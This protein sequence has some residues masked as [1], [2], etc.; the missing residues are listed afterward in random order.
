M[1][2]DLGHV[3]HMKDL[4]DILAFGLPHNVKRMCRSH[5]FF[6]ALFALSYVYLRKWHKERCVVDICMKV[7]I[8]NRISLVLCLCKYTLGTF[9]V[10]EIL[11]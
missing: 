5:I 1:I 10:K 11:G 2:P 3:D 9:F 4:P 6:V 7:D 8:V